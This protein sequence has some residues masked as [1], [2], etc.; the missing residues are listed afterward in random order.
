[1][2]EE[3]G[4]ILHYEIEVHAI[5][6]KNGLPLYLSK[7][8]IYTVTMGNA[9]F[10]LVC[11]ESLKGIKIK[12][13]AKQRLIYR[14]KYDSQIVFAFNTVSKY[15]RD[16][17]IG[18]NIPF[19]CLPNQVYLPFLGMY[20]SKS[21]SSDKSDINNKRFTPAAQLLFLLLAYSNYQKKYTKTEAAAMLN[22]TNTSITRASNQLKK[23]NLLEE[24]SYQ[25]YR[26][27][28]KTD[29][30]F[31]YLQKAMPYLINPVNDV[32]YV[33][34]TNA[35]DSCPYAGELAF[36]PWVG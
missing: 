10:I 29:K 12:T 33:K 2:F 16:V 9:E 5:K 7:R 8:D 24:Y 13:L 17:L 11:L 28:R 19:I 20:L 36:S 35:L 6:D 27:I 31:D 3:L 30:G 18:N 14:N 26:Y 25:N 21:F 34:N 15:Q 23:L 1:M 32:K 4:R 22:L